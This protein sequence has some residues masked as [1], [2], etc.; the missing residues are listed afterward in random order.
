MR[1]GGRVLQFRDVVVTPYTELL[2]YWRGLSDHKGGPAWPDWDS[3]TAA[4]HCRLGKPIDIAPEPVTPVAT[5]DGPIAWGGAAVLHFGHQIGDFSMRLLPT[6]RALPGVPIAFASHPRFK[7]APGSPP[8]WFWSILDWL[9]VPRDDAY[10]VSEPTLMRDLAVLPQAEQIGGPGPDA[11]SLDMLDELVERRL[12]TVTRTGTVYVS[13]AA[14]VARFAAE[15]HLER[16]LSASGV[17]VVR[18]E[19]MPLADQLR[20]YASADVLIFAEGSALYGIQLLGRSVGDLVFLSRR[21]KRWYGEASLAP[22]ARSLTHV[23]A[24]AGLVHPLRP[25]GEPAEEYGVTLVD[26]VRLL[27]AL[28]DLVPN[29]SRHLDSD[30]YRR[31]QQE[32]VLRWLASLDPSWT[33]SPEAM[34]HLLKTIRDTGAMRNL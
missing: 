11:A 22:R 17:T 13:R 24:T 8:D 33:S 32:D 20:L 1:T 3:Q 21:E 31:A 29:L 34:D 28:S 15:E 5:I 19:V 7:I 27:E 18:P 12:G 2:Q 6:V 23:D 25:S 14:Q 10:F 4:R 9:G 30:A 26:P 16:A